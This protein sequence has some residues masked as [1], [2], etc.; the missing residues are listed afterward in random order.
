[1]KSTVKHTDPKP[2][3]DAEGYQTN[4][5]SLNGEPLPDLHPSAAWSF[6]HGGR[7]AGAGRPLSGNEPVLFRL[8]PRLIAKI[9]RKARREGK[10]NSKLVTELLEI[11]L[12]SARS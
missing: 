2:L 4:I 11:A 10:D 5:T 3:F 6:Y 9:R 8:P 7:R 12:T 1:M